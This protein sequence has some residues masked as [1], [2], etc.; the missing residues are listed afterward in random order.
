MTKR[1]IAVLVLV[2]LICSLMAGCGKKKQQEELPLE[3]IYRIVLID[4]GEGAANAGTPHIHESTYKNKDCYAFYLTVGD[5]DIVYMV[6]KS[7]EI[8]SKEH[9]SHSH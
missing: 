3:E 8:L 4:L 6:S 1:L 2:C 7:G 9:G 5:E